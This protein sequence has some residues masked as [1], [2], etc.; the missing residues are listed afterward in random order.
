LLSTVVEAQ[1]SIC[2]LF[3]GLAGIGKS[4][5]LRNYF[6]LGQQ[7]DLIRDKF[8]LLPYSCN[9]LTST[10]TPSMFF[11]SKLR[12]VT[13]KLTEL[14]PS[15][16]NYDE[17]WDYID[18]NKPD[19]LRRYR[20]FKFVSKISDLETLAN[21]DEFAYQAMLIK[22][23]FAMPHFHHLKQII[24]VFDDVE[25]I[26]HD[27][28]HDFIEFAYHAFSCLNNKD[29]DYHVKLLLAER[30]HTRD[31]FHSLN[32]QEQRP[33]IN[34]TI[35]ASL[36][37]IFLSRHCYVMEIKNPDAVQRELWQNSFQILCQLISKLDQYGREFILE[38]TNYNIRNA[39]IAVESM[40]AQG[41]WFQTSDIHQSAFTIGSHTIRV[42]I[43]NERILKALA[44]GNRAVYLEGQ[45]GSYGLTNLLKNSDEKDS[46]IAPLLIMKWFINNLDVSDPF[47]SSNHRDK[48]AFI[49]VLRQL[50][51]LQP[52]LPFWIDKAFEH[53]IKQGII[54]CILN[55]RD[56][57]KRLYVLMPRGIVLWEEL[58][59]SSG[60]MEICID[61]LWL[62]FNIF[63]GNPIQKLSWEERIIECMNLCTHIA[64]EEKEL[65]KNLI[66]KESKKQYLQL[67]GK[68]T[69]AHHLADGIISSLRQ[70]Y[71]D[72]RPPKIQSKYSK[73]YSLINN[74]E[75]ELNETLSPHGSRIGRDRSWREQ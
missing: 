64:N 10:L 52:Q 24:I 29:R 12:V 50:T 8:V 47:A 67:F 39:M 25:A 18:K 46:D 66:T 27:K 37:E 30:P 75:G 41:R 72:A 38:L 57:T 56:S 17:L 60:F 58:S 53:F 11:A 13:D 70:V 23:L 5:V 51:P 26:N 32:W 7:N 2:Q 31:E 63:N 21:N 54:D 35:P 71:K 44:Y 9:T 4:T 45:D 34:I 42:R 20:K 3:I 19:V 22:Y 65:H 33:D 61:D 69:I 36:K 59:S 55:P 49:K 48:E 40:L 74:D 68:T 43:T 15:P 14:L 73:M 28:R 62:D 16:I 1:Q 6:K